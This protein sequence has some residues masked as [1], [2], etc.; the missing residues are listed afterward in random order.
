[1]PTKP[2]QRGFI[3]FEKNIDSKNESGMILVVGSERKRLLQVVEKTPN[4]IFLRYK[5]PRKGAFVFLIKNIDQALL[6][7]YSI[8]VSSDLVRLLPATKLYRPD[9]SLT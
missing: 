6:F 8:V 1:M 2:R 9:F 3:F 7:D 5:A 4:P